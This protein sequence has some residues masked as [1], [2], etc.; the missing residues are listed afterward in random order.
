MKVSVHHATTTSQVTSGSEG[1][2]ANPVSAG[3]GATRGAAQD[4]SPRAS[5]LDLP[6][7]ILEQITKR[8]E[9]HDALASIE[10][11]STMRNLYTP[12][13]ITS[14]TFEKDC[15]NLLHNY[16]LSNKRQKA[17]VESA[18][19]QVLLKLFDRSTSDSELKQMTALAE[20][21][22]EYLSAADMN[23]QLSQVLSQQRGHLQAQL[24]K[25]AQINLSLC[26]SLYGI[27]TSERLRL[28]GIKNHDFLSDKLPM[29][30][31]QAE[32]F[33]RGM[34]GTMHNS[35]L[36][37][38]VRH[39]SREAVSAFLEANPA[40][41]DLRDF[42]GGETP[43]TYASF[44][45]DVDMVRL[46]LAR[47]ANVNARDVVVNKTSLLKVASVTAM[48]KKEAGVQIAK[49]LLERGADIE[50]ADQFGRTPLILACLSGHTDMVHLLLWY[51][52]DI[53]ANIHTGE[54]ALTYARA[55]GHKDIVQILEHYQH[56]AG[57]FRRLG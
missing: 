25:L 57:P 33:L 56:L 38:A 26:A 40:C 29:D 46:L 39:G 51:G 49:A 2:T 18:Y 15:L 32:S 5:L 9:A 11:S 54:D 31:K 8:L 55:R 14:L 50:S 6:N 24:E 37:Y 20:Q 12:E 19:Q 53:N 4:T 41:I 48:G 10:A 43:L 34:A 22:Y 44:Q 30:K 3:E 21:F 42:F 52:A 16:E 28:Y 17:E 23:A 27:A 35:A 1:E 13:E 45:G 7:E 36:H 47:G